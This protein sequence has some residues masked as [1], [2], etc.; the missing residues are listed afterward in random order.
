LPAS[1][2]ISAID[3][4]KKKIPP[5]P[6]RKRR[7]NSPGELHHRHRQRCDLIIGF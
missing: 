5:T 4:L 2:S 7:S 6:M 1:A 3:S